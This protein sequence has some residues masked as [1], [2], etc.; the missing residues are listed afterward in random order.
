MYTVNDYNITSKGLV[1]K[2][3]THPTRYKKCH[4]KYYLE[5]VTYFIG[6]GWSC[7]RIGKFYI[8]LYAEM[9]RG[10]L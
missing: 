5:S 6:C 7:V 2:T 4:K 9:C 8:M 10:V 3:V 1:K